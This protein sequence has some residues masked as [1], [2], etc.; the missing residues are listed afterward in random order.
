MGVRRRISRTAL[1][2][3]ALLCVLPAHAL[4]SHTQQSILMDDDQF[5]YSDAGHVARALSEIKA[6]GVDRV[7][8]S[9]VW[10]L[11]APDAASTHKPNFDATNPDAYP[12]GAWARWDRIVTYA[13]SIGLGVYL[14]IVP[15]APLWAVGKGKP[16][17]GYASSQTPSAS[18]FGKFVEAVARRYS[19]TYVAHSASDRPHPVPDLPV[20]VPGVFPTATDPTPPIPKVDFWGIWNEPNEAGW[21]NPQ[22]TTVH[23]RRQFDTAPAMYR[24]L[25]DAAYHGLAVTGHASDTIL[26]GELAARGY[27]YPIPFMQELYC[28]DSRSR[29]LTGRAAR[30]IGCPSSGSRSAFEARHPGL[31]RSTGL[32]YHP[33]SFD[34]PPNVPMSDPNW[35]TF[36]N[37]GRL[38]RTVD[39]AFS[40]YGQ[41]RRGGVPIYMT[42]FGYKSNPPNPY[43]K[44]SLSE[45]AMWLNQ[46]DYLAYR[47]PRVKSVAQF[48][49]VDDRPRAGA[50]VGSRA[51]WSTF[52]SG[53]R[54]TSGKKK[55]SYAAYRLPIWIPHARHGS[56]VFIWG[57]LRPANHHQRQSAVLQYRASGSHRWKAVKTLQTT[58]SEG[59][60]AVYEPIRSAGHVRLAWV[61]SAGHTY[62]SRSVAIS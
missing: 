16:T 52:Q 59:Y 50:A 3:C 49:L 36:A 8:V 14:Q 56:R 15:P 26:I 62:Y 23:G 54:Y 43:V 9:V 53:L 20:T 41:H 38:Q 29:P 24:H 37:L 22:W 46:S 13:R 47:N 44:T 45:Q 11:V 57:Q 5:I 18:D 61:D 51:Y 2:V 32:A 48:L 6:L 28:V 35:I 55:P 19:G 60:L 12:P 27:I 39:H 4:A 10:S 58:N 21:L 7:K 40:A 31:L 25:V 17:Q 34:Q 1:A 42:E 30:E 33:Y